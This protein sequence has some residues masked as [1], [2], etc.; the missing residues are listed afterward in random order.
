M[1]DGWRNWAGNQRSRPV[2]TVHARDAEAVA[3]A[4][5]AAAARDLRVT[6]L[7]SGHSF[8]GI[9]TPDGVAIR[10]P[11][12]PARIRFDDGQVHVPAGVTLHTLNRWLWRNGRSLPNL[13]D[14]E[15]QTVA[16]AISTGTHGTGAAKQGIAAGVSAVE[17]VLADGSVR[18]CTGGPD[19]DAARVGL[20]ALGVLTE[21]TLRTEPAFRLRTT[22]S[23][24]PLPEVL[25]TLDDLATAH[26]HVEFFWFPHTEAAVLKLGDR[27]EDP[28]DRSRVSAFVGDEV[29]GNAGFGLAQRVGAAAPVLVPRLNRLMAARM[30]AGTYAGPSHEV[31]CTPR[32][33]R[34][35]EMEYAVPREALGEAFAGVRAAA[36]RHGGDVTFPVE[37]RVLGPDEAWMSTAHDRETAY[38]ALHVPYRRER[39]RSAGYFGAVEPVLAGLGGRPHW[40]KLHTRTAAQLRPVYPRFDAFVAHRDRLDPEGRFRNP[41]LDR[42]LGVPCASRS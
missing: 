18:R 21:V 1:V 29:L 7:G 24:R 36:R 35:V 15:A 25:A 5:R 30:A 2:R 10:A 31:F 12:D 33:V 4:V 26:D 23:T 14:I 11:A 27:T 32:R 19:L 39:T 22:E 13:G 20:G 8:T 28:P 16:G 41:Y 34:F 3:D 38:L 9:G 17:M 37:V 6:A 40:G 42:V